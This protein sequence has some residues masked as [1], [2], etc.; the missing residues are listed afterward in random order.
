MFKLILIIVLQNGSGSSITTSQ[1]EYT[2]KT[3]AQCEYAQKFYLN[4]AVQNEL[5]HAPHTT[6]N[7]SAQC[8]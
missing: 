3:Q 5:K 2:F 4:P 7:V 6:I 1:A 8:F